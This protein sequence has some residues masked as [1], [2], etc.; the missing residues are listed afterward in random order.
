MDITDGR[1]WIE[2][3]SRKKM[4]STKEVRNEEPKETW[5]AIESIQIHR[6][7]LFP[8]KFQENKRTNLQA[9]RLSRLF[10]TFVALLSPE[11]ESSDY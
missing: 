5:K 8:Q 2:S 3:S 1:R 6:R 10:N 4:G 7:I 9:N 11:I